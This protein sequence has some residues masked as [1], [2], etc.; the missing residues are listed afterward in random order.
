MKILRI[1]K[2]VSEMFS[3]INPSAGWRNRHIPEKGDSWKSV[4]GKE[5]FTVATCERGIPHIQK[6]LN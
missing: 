6:H 2:G 1:S 4:S 5:R 3:F